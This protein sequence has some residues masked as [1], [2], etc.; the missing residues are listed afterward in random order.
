MKNIEQRSTGPFWQCLHLSEQFIVVGVGIQG[1]TNPVG[2]A[3]R[4]DI[5][6]QRFLLCRVTGIAIDQYLVVEVDD[7]LVGCIGKGGGQK[8]ADGKLMGNPNG[9]GGGPGPTEGGGGQ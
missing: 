5:S 3:V 4:L 9:R 8:L 7:L 2:D 6:H 1:T